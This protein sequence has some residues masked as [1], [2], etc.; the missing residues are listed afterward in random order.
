MRIS[1]YCEL[2]LKGYE[3]L[4]LTAYVCPAGKRTI[5]WGHTG[6]VDGMEVP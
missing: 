3:N 4:E 6:K 5:G 1:E 2:T